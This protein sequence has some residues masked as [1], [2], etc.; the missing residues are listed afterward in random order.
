MQLDPAIASAVHQHAVECRKELDEKA[1]DPFISY[2]SE[3]RN[4]ELASNLRQVAV[5]VN[6]AVPLPVTTL[7]DLM[8]IRA[9]LALPVYRYETAFWEQACF[10][11]QLIFRA[12]PAS[13]PLPLLPSQ[14]TVKKAKDKP[15]SALLKEVAEALQY[16]SGSL[17]SERHARVALEG[18]V[19]LFNLAAKTLPEMAADEAG[20]IE[21][22]RMATSF[23]SHSQALP[24]PLSL[25]ECCQRLQQLQ[26]QNHKP[27]MALA[28]L[29]SST[30]K[31][32]A[33]NT[34]A[35]IEALCK[36]YTL[37]PEDGVVWGLLFELLS[38]PEARNRLMRQLL[39]RRP[40]HPLFP[41]L[42]TR[43]LSEGAIIS[44]LQ[45]VAPDCSI[46]RQ[47]LEQHLFG[48]QSLDQIR[49]YLGFRILRSGLGNG[50]PIDNCWM[51]YG[52]LIRACKAYKSFVLKEA[53]TEKP[54]DVFAEALIEAPL[55]GTLSFV[56]EVLSKMPLGIQQRASQ[57]AKIAIDPEPFQAL[58]QACLE[59]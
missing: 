31:D 30:W 45:Q 58:Y 16:L 10:I 29:H 39:A 20:K 59:V 32:R 51:G 17:F 23:A 49:A 53:C 11:D 55:Q 27:L 52:A 54:E 24:F 46:Q 15:C 57:T 21:F 9:R 48:Y 40:C 1:V 6:Q 4:T 28:C 33:A 43:L 26:P 14:G 56:L 3:R 13:T 5:K 34:Q 47:V 36:A 50:A 8:I 7:L 44:Y 37:Q 22:L 12:K 19:K 2:R 18:V 25:E 35:A 42:N 38:I 41:L